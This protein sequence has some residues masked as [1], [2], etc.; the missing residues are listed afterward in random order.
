MRDETPRPAPG[1]GFSWLYP[2]Q[3]LAAAS[4]VLGLGL[5]PLLEWAAG[6]LLIAI[7]LFNLLPAFAPGRRISEVY[8]HPATRPI[9]VGYGVFLAAIIA[10]ALIFFASTAN[11]VVLLAGAVLAFVATVIF[12][13]LMDAT[14]AAAREKPRR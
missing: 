4:L 2:V 14:L 1:D 12:G 11:G 3:G 6:F 5:A 9:A 7:A 10:G 13:P 8:T